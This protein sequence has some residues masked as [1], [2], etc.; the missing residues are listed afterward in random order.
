MKPIYT[1]V[2]TAFLG[3]LGACNSEETTQ[4]N[5]QNTPAANTAQNNA[6]SKNTPSS[7]QAESSLINWLTMEE[8][9]EK[10]KS[11]PR[12]VVIDLYT[13]WCGWCK[14]MDKATFQ[15]PD[16][17]AY[18]NKNF[19]AVKLDAETKETLSFRGQKWEFMPNPNGRK[20]TNKLAAVIILGNSP[21]GRIGYPTIAFLDENLNR[22]DAYPGYRGPDKFEGL[23]KFISENHYKTQQLE[24][25]LQKFT[26]TIP[27]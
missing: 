10:M 2:L 26:P 7:V 17:A 16:V 21:T 4:T 9:E 3:F 1:I 13:D 19:Y 25:F 11:E 5:N 14:K 12:K 6:G 15:H 20:G 24:Q 22:I 18:I 23:M 27:G 8:M